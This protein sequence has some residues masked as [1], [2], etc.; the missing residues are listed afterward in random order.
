MRDDLSR[1]GIKFGVIIIPSKV[2]VIRGW[3]IANE[4]PVQNEFQIRSEEG[5][6]DAYLEYFRDSRI[7]YID[8]TPFVVDAFG[9]DSRLG[10]AFYPFGDGHPYYS[11]YR[12]YAEAAAALAEKLGFH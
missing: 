12:S 8:A 5:L 7:E 11:G 6:I 4:I 1:K 10:K 3:A 2:R 9:V